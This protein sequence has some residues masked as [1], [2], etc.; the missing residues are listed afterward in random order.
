MS[1]TDSNLPSDSDAHVGCPSVSGSA[2]DWPEI[3]T[4]CVHGCLLVL[5]ALMF[6]FGIV[7]IAISFLIS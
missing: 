6:F 1:A 7:G 3:A 5:A 2:G 4:G